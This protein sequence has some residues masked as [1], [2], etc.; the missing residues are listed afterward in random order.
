MGY[1]VTLDLGEL[2]AVGQALA[3]GLSDACTITVRATVRAG[4]REALSRRTWKN[5]SGD[6]ERKTKGVMLVE[7]RGGALGELKCDVKYASYLDAGTPPHD[8]IGNPYL[9]FM[10]KGIPMTLRRVRHPG[11]RGD[12]FMGYAFLKM[13]SFGQAEM[14]RQA[15]LIAERF[16]RRLNAA[17]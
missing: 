17:A 16:E 5:Q 14:E 8:I 1:N 11:T 10:W 7:A 6:A 3:T 15:N 2:E 13:E 9:H 12:G 4:E